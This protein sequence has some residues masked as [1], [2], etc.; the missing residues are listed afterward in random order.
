MKPKLLN[1]LLG[2]MLLFVAF[3]CRDQASSTTAAEPTAAKTDD[4]AAKNLETAKSFYT[5]FEKGDWAGLQKII[6]PEITDHSPMWPRGDTTMPGDSLIQ[7]LKVNKEGFPDMKFEVLH[8]AADGDHVFV[9]YHFTGTNTGPMMG[10]PASNKKV[11]YKGVDLVRMK[12]GVAV[13]HWDYGD[14][15]AFMKQMGMMPEPKK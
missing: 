4:A 3:A 6:G 13:E 10:A 2:V 14:N 8:V 1:F 11:D 5:L 15:I 7:L 12:D 9:H